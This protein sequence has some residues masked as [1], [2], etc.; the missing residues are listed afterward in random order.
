VSKM[1]N[2]IKVECRNIQSPI[3]AV[4]GQFFLRNFTTLYNI[5]NYIKKLLYTPILLPNSLLQFFFGK[6]TKYSFE[7]PPM[8]GITHN[9]LG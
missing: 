5:N 1:I 3:Y 2:K 6:M 7:S 4:F 9:G 8:S